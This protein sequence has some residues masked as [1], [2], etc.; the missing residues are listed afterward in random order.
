MEHDVFRKPVPTFRHHAL[1]GPYFARPKSLDLGRYSKPNRPRMS[2]KPA[3][4]PDAAVGDALRAVARDILAEALAA[5][6]DPE[7]SDATAVHDYRKA[8]A[9]GA[10][11]LRPGTPSSAEEGERTRVEARALA[12]ERAGARDA[13]AALEG[14]ED[15]KD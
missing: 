13:Q 8:M 11:L 2:D 10:A 1:A 9:R 5:L 4:R 14:V 3:I 15:L 6:D 12:R 7:K